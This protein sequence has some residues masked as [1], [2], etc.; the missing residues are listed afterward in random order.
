MC[1]YRANNGTQVFYAKG[2]TI[3]YGIQDAFQRE[4]LEA[5]VQNPSLVH[6]VVNPYK[7]FRIKGK[8]NLTSRNQQKLFFFDKQNVVA[9]YCI[10]PFGFCDSK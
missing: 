4:A 6:T 3:N 9:G 7:V 8:W 10:L 1:A 2:T 5:M